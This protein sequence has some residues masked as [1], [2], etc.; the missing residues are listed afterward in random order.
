[1]K[2]GE[3]VALTARFKQ[4][5]IICPDQVK[6]PEITIK[7][8]IRALSDFVA[9]FVQ[10]AKMTTIE[11]T[12]LLAAEINDKRVKAGFWDKARRTCT[13]LQPLQPS[14]LLPPLRSHPSP[15][16]AKGRTT[17][18]PATRT[19]LLQ[20]LPHSKLYQ[21]ISSRNTDKL[22][23]QLPM[24]HLQSVHILVLT[25]LAR[26]VLI[27]ILWES[28]VDTVCIAICTAISPPTAIRVL[29][30]PQLHLKFQLLLIKLCSPL[31]KANK[32]LLQPRSMPDLASH[33]VILTTCQ[34]CAQTEWL[35]KSPSSSSS[36]SN[37]NS[38]RRQHAD[39]PSTS[40]SVKL[41][42]TTMWLMR[43]EVLVGIISN[44]VASINHVGL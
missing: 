18:T 1:M 21:L 32:P 2:D 22:Q 10:A 23:H 29:V 13:K 12:F 26:R 11:E 6:T 24:H 5:S 36:P 27:I 25:L 14:K 42:P 34:M 3:N 17:T 7:K 16:V 15:L 33:V 30:T 38:S 28:P 43:I 40:S 9:D 19:V 41:K 44:T 37:S 8:Y 35:N 39:A 31:L 20:P 4:L